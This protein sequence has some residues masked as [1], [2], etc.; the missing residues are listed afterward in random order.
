MKSRVTTNLKTAVTF[1]GPKLKLFLFL[2]PMGHVAASVHVSSDMSAHAIDVHK[3]TTS[4]SEVNPLCS[5][6]CVTLKA[7]SLTW[8]NL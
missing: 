4:R 5:V 1:Y 2:Q 8:Q 3:E 7:S 6:Y